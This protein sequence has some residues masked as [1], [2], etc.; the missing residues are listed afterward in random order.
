MPQV[1]P[2]SHPGQ[3]VNSQA[4]EKELRS[5]LEGEVRFDR[6]S[7]ALYATDGSNYRQVP[8]GVVLPKSKADVIETLRICR[9]HGAPVLARGGGTSLAG[10]CCN[11]AVVLDFTKYLHH[12][13]EIDPARKLARVEPGTILDHLRNSANEVGLTFAPDPSTHNHCVLGGMI[14][15]NSCGT[16]SMMAGRT[17]DN[18]EELEILTYDGVRMR[19]G[20][21]S[22]LELARIIAEGGRRGEIYA[23]LK[24]LR[25]KYAPL[26]RARY[27][28]IPRRVSGYNLDDLLP[29]N[30]FHVAR[31]L[32]GSEGTC[33]TILE[34]TVNLVPNPPC[35]AV[36]V[37]GYPDVYQA[38]D[39]IPQ[40]VEYEPI[41]L[42]GLDNQLIED[43]IKT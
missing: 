33:V 15:N 16:H 41:A 37:L 27:P 8:I 11:V 26:I 2:I 29:E 3:P 34:S 21:T 40:I 32:V 30:G 42:E 4:L 22:D 43:T 5:A 9:E 10:Q 23:R 18:V 24:A 36:L 31:A 14:G 7:R 35:R 20:R 12:V 13:L 17:A 38:A 39:H 28:K 25:D 19:V 1:A 6:G